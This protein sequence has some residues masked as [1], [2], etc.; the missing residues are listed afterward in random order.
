[1]NSDR[2]L[3]GYGANP[4]DI[5]WPNGA[6]VAV[7]VVVNFEEGAE[8]QVGDGDATS[9][10][11]G[12]ILSVVPDGM[13]DQGQE[14]IFAYGLRRGFW[15]FMN[16]LDRTA[17]PAT[18][19]MCGRA[20]ERAPELARVVTGK[21]HEAAC[22]GWQ[23]RPHAEYGDR[24][25]ERVDLMRASD[26]ISRHTGQMPLGFF[27]RGSE[28]PWTRDLLAGMGYAYTSNA[29]DDDL[30]YA[31]ASGLIVLPYN[32]DTNDMKF[33]HPNGFVRPAEMVD[34]VKGALDQLLEEAAQGASSTLSIGFHLR[35]TGRPA[36][37]RAADEIFR[38]LAQHD[39]RIWRARRID[40]VRHFKTWRGTAG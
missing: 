8:Q 7:S 35:I 38:L 15:R 12:E 34:Y 24:D 20:V 17:T 18:F 31:D 39:G 36:R 10:R 1:M 32:L 5:V 9:E 28:S 14:Q 3:V 11:V 6:R 22:H 33:F 26:A 30:P 16:A 25:A 21:G 27:C 13:R 23:W 19:F 2:D 37:F 29:F 40:I 4:P